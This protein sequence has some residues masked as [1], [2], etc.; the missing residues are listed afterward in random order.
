[1]PSWTRVIS[2]AGAHFTDP[3]DRD[4]TDDADVGVLGAMVEL[5][6]IAHEP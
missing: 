6:V 3:G 1:M 5:G 4:A 2:E